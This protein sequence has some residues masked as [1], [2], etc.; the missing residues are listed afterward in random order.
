MSDKGYRDVEEN[1]NL[2]ALSCQLK[3][4]SRKLV[5]LEPGS[6]AQVLP[7]WKFQLN[8]ASPASSISR[9]LACLANPILASSVSLRAGSRRHLVRQQAAVLAEERMQDCSV[10]GCLGSLLDLSVCQSTEYTRL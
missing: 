8:W 7:S 4:A 5:P 10:L 6:S 9:Y 2:F 3:Q 1:D